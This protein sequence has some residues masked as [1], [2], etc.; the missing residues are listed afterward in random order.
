MRIGSTAWCWG[1]LQRVGGFL[2]FLGAV[3]FQGCS[4]LFF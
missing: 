2:F 3:D 4:C 1:R